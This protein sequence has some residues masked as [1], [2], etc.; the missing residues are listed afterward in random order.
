MRKPGKAAP[1]VIDNRLKRIP[2]NAT[3]FTRYDLNQIMANLL[4]VLRMKM[5]PMAA[6][7]D[8]KRQKIEVPSSSS[9]LSQTPAI[10]NTPP[11]TKLT[12]MPWRLMSQLQGKAKIGC[13]MVKRSAL[14]VI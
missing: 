6:S 3:M 11:T 8:P 12:R 2:V 14:R 13:A 7:P 9:N 1:S 10:T 5:L 4:G